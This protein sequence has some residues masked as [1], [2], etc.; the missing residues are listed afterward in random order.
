MN[1]KTWKKLEHF[2]HGIPCN[3][4]CCSHRKEVKTM[5]KFEENKH[6]V[7]AIVCHYRFDNFVRPEINYMCNVHTQSRGAGSAVHGRATSGFKLRRRSQTDRHL[8]TLL[9]Q[10]MQ[11]MMWSRGCSSCARC[12]HSGRRGGGRSLVMWTSSD[13]QPTA[14]SS[15]HPLHADIDTHKTS[16][17]ASALPCHSRSASSSCHPLT[18]LPTP[19]HRQAAPASETRWRLG[20]CPSRW[21]TPGSGCG[22]RRWPVE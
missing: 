13:S 3:K 4:S 7:V 11:R 21:A 19:S 2:I 17:P 10:G 6:T 1:N 16:G 8:G 14:A 9:E 12:G 18:P 22:R 20:W 15:V 5:K